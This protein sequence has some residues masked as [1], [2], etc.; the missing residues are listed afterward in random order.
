MSPNKYVREQ[1]GKKVNCVTKYAGASGRQDCGGD[2]NWNGEYV[3]PCLHGR[4]QPGGAEG[5]LGCI[6]PGYTARFFFLRFSLQVMICFGQV[7]AA[8]VDAAFG[9]VSTDLTNS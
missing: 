5:L 7:V 8:I 2:G 4:D 6:F 3:H 1:F 9:E